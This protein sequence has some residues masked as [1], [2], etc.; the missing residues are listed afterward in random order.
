VP[1]KHYQVGAVR[2]IGE[3]SSGVT[4]HDALAC[5]DV[6]ILLSPVGQ[7]VGQLTDRSGLSGVRIPG[8]P[9]M[10]GQQSRLPE[11]GRLEG[12]RECR[13]TVLR[14]PY[15]DGNQAMRGAGLSPHHHDRARGMHGG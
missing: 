9:R 12:E 5:V 6:G 13:I 14:V 7:Q 8:L 15:T 11:L 3:H 4:S 10:D 1:A 2:Q